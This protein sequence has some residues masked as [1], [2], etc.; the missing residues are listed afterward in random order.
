[1]YLEAHLVAKSEQ[2]AFEIPR[3]LLVNNQSV[4]VLKD[5]VID[6]ERV[7]PVYFTDETVVIKGLDNG[8]PMVSRIVPGAYPGMV[9]KVY[10]EK[11]RNAQ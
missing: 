8:T 9:V 11:N 2:D 5:S 10:E 7:N 1:M 3:K 4:Y 6:L